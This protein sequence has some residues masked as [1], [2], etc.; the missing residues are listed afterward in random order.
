M[1]K[2]TAEKET[3]KKRNQIN[4]QIKRKENTLSLK[5]KQVKLDLKLLQ[6]LQQISR[7]PMKIKNLLKK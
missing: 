1:P 7:V 6:D 2:K 3:V 5:M 4:N